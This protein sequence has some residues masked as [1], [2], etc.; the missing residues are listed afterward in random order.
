[1]KRIYICH[2]VYQVLI[3]LLKMDIKN[4]TLLSVGIVKN[5]PN[6]RN[7]LMA[8]VNLVEV[9]EYTFG[10][11]SM[12][13]TL[14]TKNWFSFFKN[15]EEIIIF[16]DHRQVGHFLNKHKLPYFLIEDGYNFFKDKRVCHLEPIQS[17]WKRILYR[18]YFR[19]A[20]LIG[21][22]PYCQS[23]EVNDLSLV[24]PEQAYKPFVEVPRKNLFDSISQERLEAI[25][26][27]F[28][29]KS[30]FNNEVIKERRVLL[31]TQP[32]SWE[33]YVTDEERLEIYL[34]G[35]RPYYKDYKIYIKPHPRDSFDYSSLGDGII[36]FPQDIPIELFEL[37]G[38]MNFDVGITY[39]S[40]SMDY[41]D[42]FDE[43]VYLHEKFPLPSK[44][45]ID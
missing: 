24:H 38:Y 27:I 13:H 26:Q 39:S 35:L 28:G 20:T 34:A 44:T 21:S 36:I 33:F 37:A 1:M 19:P 3:S 2:T 16:L 30:L 15:F 9:E 5:F 40:S 18:W 22:S 29:V 42:C 10:L 8:Y 17:S 11:R 7:E 43:K 32:L 25:V 14:E 45:K 41:L 12:I 31:L 23:I 4:D 6:M